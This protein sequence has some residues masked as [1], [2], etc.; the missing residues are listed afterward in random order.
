M[1]PSIRAFLLLS[2]QLEANRLRR[3]SLMLSI[4]IGC[5]GGEG[6]DLMRSSE[7]DKFDRVSHATVLHHGIYRQNVSGARPHLARTRDSACSLGVCYGVWTCTSGGHPL[8]T[9]KTQN[10]CARYAQGF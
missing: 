6:S 2:R 8:F 7:T 10:A 1:V 4:L 5:F 3:S 9:M